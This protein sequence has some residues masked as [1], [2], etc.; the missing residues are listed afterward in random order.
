VD[1]PAQ[2]KKSMRDGSCIFRDNFVQMSASV[3]FDVHF[4]HKN[5]Y[6]THLR[7][8]YIYVFFDKIN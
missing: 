6:K 5:H 1:E 8:I 3:G 2:L 7:C 4:L